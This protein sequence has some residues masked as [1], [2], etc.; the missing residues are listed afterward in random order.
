MQLVH[1]PLSTLY[2][3]QGGWVLSGF[4]DTDVGLIPAPTIYPKYISGIS[5]I[6]INILNFI[7]PQNIPILYPIGLTN[8]H[9]IHRN[10]LKNSQKIFLPNIIFIF[11]P[12]KQKSYCIFLI[13][14]PLPPNLVKPTNV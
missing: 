6:P 9:K 2:V 14:E 11:D 5:G 4:L 7:N 12:L 3:S 10:D 1:Y 13:F 8:D